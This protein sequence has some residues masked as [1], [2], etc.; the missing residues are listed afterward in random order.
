[1]SK[2]TIMLK[3]SKSTTTLLLAIVNAFFVYAGFMVPKYLP[4]DVSIATMM[5]ITV[6]VNALIVYLTTTE[7]S[8]QALLADATGKEE[9]K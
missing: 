7:G 4:A 6:I 3:L 8:T 9:N 2:Q 1:M 5:A